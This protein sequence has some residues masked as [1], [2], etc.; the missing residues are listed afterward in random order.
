MRKGKLALTD[1]G[2][3]LTLREE[4]IMSNLPERIPIFGK[5]IRASNR[6][7]TG[8]LNKL[9]VDIFNDIIRKSETAGKKLTDRELEDIGR[10]INAGTGKGE[11]FSILKDAA[12]G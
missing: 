8:F 4:A 5:V 6:A 1:L 12:P 7:Y 9:R 10:F 2:G 11:L 3:A